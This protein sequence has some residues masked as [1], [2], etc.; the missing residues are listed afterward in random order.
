[1]ET[2]ASPGIMFTATVF[3]VVIGALVFVHELG[4]Y[5]AARLFGIEVDTFA[6]GFGRE[7][8][9]WTDRSGTRWKLG[10]LPLGGYAKFRGDMNAA[11]QPDP[12]LAALP[13]AERAGLFQFR[14]LW[15]R[16]LVV[17]AGPA[18]NFLFAILVF[19]IF[20][21]A[22]GERYALPVAGAVME[23]APAAVAGIRPGDRFVAV[24]GHRVERFEDVMRSV[25]LNPG[26]PVRLAVER[27]GQRLE[28]TLTPRIITETDRFGNSFRRGMIGVTS[29]PVA[30]RRL[31]P[32]QAVGAAVA[33]TGAIIRMM[34]DTL[35]QVLSGRRPLDDMGG[36]LRIAQYSGQTAAM[37]AASLIGFMALISINL[38]FINLLPVPMLD[39]GHLLLYLLEAARR[40]PLSPKVQE[41]AFLSGFALL[42]SLMLI[43]TWNDL[44]SMGL[45]ERVA[46]LIG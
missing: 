44:G 46:R 13:A 5:L 8:V 3:V 7:L 24:D 6:I 18:V 42:M 45:W 27:G 38:G 4:H 1:M 40:R 31:G 11:S 25:V 29:G 30:M 39:G 15:Q 9:G 21:M 28:I 32:A 41:W 2:V 34:G 14:P 33:E 36:P 20:F 12:A 35:W 37:G 19:A 23:D 10:W 16:A 43:L 26:R 17:A 22:W